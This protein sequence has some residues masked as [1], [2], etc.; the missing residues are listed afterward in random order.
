MELQSILHSYLT[1]LYG[2]DAT[3]RE[4]QLKAIVSTV[5]NHSTLVVE[6]TGWGKSLVYFLAT[7]YF[8]SR[9]A[10]PTIVVSPLRSLMRNQ[11]ETAEKL[12]L[13]AVVFS[14][15]FYGEKEELAQFKT[16]LKQDL[17]DLIFI[18]P[19]Q[20]SKEDVRSLLIDAGKEYSLIVV[21]EV[22]CIS[23]W[24]HDFRPAFL[25]IRKF[26]K[27]ILSRNPNLHMLATT[28]TAN[29][30][31]I[32]DLKHQF[33][34]G[35]ETNVIRG[36]LTRESIHIN[37]VKN[38]NYEEK[39]AWIVEY[40]KNKSGS[41]I[42]YCQT[43]KSCE[44]LSLFLIS[45][46]I[47]ARAYHSKLTSET[48]EELETLFS[49]NKIKVLVATTALGMGYDKPDIAFVIHFNRPA[50][51]L[52]YYQQIGRAGRGIKEADA[53]L[54]SNSEDDR[55]LDFFMKNAFPKEEVLKDLLD[56][57]EQRSS[58]KLSDLQRNFN[59]KQGDILSALKHLESRDLVIK[60]GNCYTRT[61]N[62]YD[63]D[64][65]VEEKEKI[66]ENRYHELKRMHDYENFSGCLMEF[67]SRE[68]NDPY[69]H[70]CGKCQ[71]CTQRFLSPAV[72]EDLKRAAYDFVNKSYIRN[73][74]INMIEP[75]KKIH[76]QS[77]FKEYIINSGFFLCKYNIGFIPK[78]LRN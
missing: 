76:S 59:L 17:Y 4:D 31:V 7:K 69:S 24:G 3:F 35:S 63:L 56:F 33:G 47:T 11:K 60:D 72:N 42:I 50:S 5:T 34:G 13:K 62:K 6:K 38:L 51:I 49:E 52:E 48:R 20:L 45:N 18:T 19:E 21:D 58:A 29:D 30:L 67:I 25:N 28:A 23:E 68:L 55:T 8:R 66:T 44:L 53:V 75:R 27:N 46:H 61:A 78:N 22:H 74:E 9:G 1:E 54:L 2:K 77:I 16:D 41:G 73:P 14:G 71:N 36:P 64:S 65:Y 39:C 37:L 57:L 43:V 10:A 40:L 70:K 15:E 12:K 26:V 32:E